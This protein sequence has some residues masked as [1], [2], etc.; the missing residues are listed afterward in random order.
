ML[1]QFLKYVLLWLLPLLLSAEHVHW[2]GDYNRALQIAHQT[3]KPL[4]VLVVQKNASLSSKI[5][6]NV[7]MDQKYV[8][9]INEKMVPVIVTYE[10]VLSYPVEMYYTTVFPTLFFVDSQR[11][12]FLREPLYG[13]SI[14][15]EAIQKFYEV[16]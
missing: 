15:K 9:Q 3:D 11:E 5:I 14:T 6:K 13:E 2:L 4:L 7:F 1:K 8:A 12:L 16:L 10:G